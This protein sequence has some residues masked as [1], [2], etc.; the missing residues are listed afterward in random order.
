MKAKLPLF[1][2]IACLLL[3]A[4]LLPISNFLPRKIQNDRVGDGDFASFTKVMQESCADCHSSSSLAADPIYARFPLAST[5]IA[6]DRKEAQTVLNLSQEQLTGTE[7]ISPPDLYRIASSVSNGSMPPGRYR[8]LHWKGFSGLTEGDKRAVLRYVQG[9]ST[10]IQCR[11]LPVSLSAPPSL[12]VELGRKLFFEKRLSAHKKLS[13]AGCHA[14]DKGGADALPV[15]ISADPSGRALNTP[16]VFNAAL[17]FK[18]YWDGRTSD[19]KQQALVSLSSAGEM[20]GLTEDRLAELR[21]DSAYSGLAESA[22]GVPLSPDVIADAIAVF[23]QTLITPGCKFDRYLKGEKT[24]LSGQALK[25]YFLF[26]EKGCVSCH[27]GMNLGGMTFE[28][29]GIKGD[30]FAH[31]LKNGG[32]KINEA[33]LGRF[34]VTRLEADRYR[35]KVPALRNVALT[36]PYFHNGSVSSLEEA[37]QDMARFQQGQELSREEVTCLVEFLKSLTGKLNS[38]EQPEP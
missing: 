22:Y 10:R 2:A 1:F 34:N 8:A 37:V 17:N 13:C 35:F 25:G 28:K 19:L 15:A 21:S 32:K 36:A 23:E 30:Y 33:D 26:Q 14:P 5:L 18:Q 29:M 3:G 7:P 24:A 9:V 6:R 4:L 27:S 38:Q 16:T 12:Q 11:P 31:R 20:G